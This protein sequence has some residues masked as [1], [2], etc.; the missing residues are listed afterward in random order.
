MIHESLKLFGLDFRIDELNMNNLP[1]ELKAGRFFFRLSCSGLAFILVKL[2]SDEKF[3]VVAFEKQAEQISGKVNLPVAFGFDRLSRIQRDSLIARDIP[4]IMTADQMYLPFLG[5]ALS[6]RF[7]SL[8]KTRTEKM[9][10]VTQ[11]LFLYMLYQSKGM[12]VIKKDAAEAIR[13]T[14]T[15]ITRASEQLAAMHLISQETKGKET[16]MRLSGK[17]LDCYEKARPFMINPVQRTIIV[18]KNPVYENIPL[19]GASVLERN[20]TEQASGMPVRAVL[21][22]AACAEELSEAE[23]LREPETDFVKLELWKYDPALFAKDGTVDPV[24]LAMSLGKT[25]DAET[26]SVI[27]TILREY[28]WQ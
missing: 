16:R 22:S 18:R 15:S 11:A 21:K 17:G 7:S 3:G 20:M 9:M 25:A 4:F 1:A 19:C 27:E 13:A 28:P 24:S 10:P 5:I 8:K 12:P 6:D 23:L 14:R 2:P 26:E